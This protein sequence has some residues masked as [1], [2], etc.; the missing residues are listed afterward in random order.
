MTRSAPWV[1]HNK[2]GPLSHCLVHSPDV[3]GCQVVHVHALNI[4]VA[5]C[6]VRRD[7]HELYPTGAFSLATCTDQ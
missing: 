3:G 4:T 6:N 1:V 7:W 5:D 2:E